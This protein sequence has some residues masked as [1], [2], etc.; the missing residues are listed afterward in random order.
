[1]HPTAVELR[2]TPTH[3]GQDLARVRAPQD[4][5]VLDLDPFLRAL[6]LHQ[7]EEEEG[8]EEEEVLVVDE[9]QTRR[10][11][12]VGGDE[13]RVTAAI[14]VMTTEAGAEVGHV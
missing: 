14:A 2:G 1:M 7:E 3:T 10:G 11:M 6:G 12:V 13:T 9:E 8:A 5:T 4:V